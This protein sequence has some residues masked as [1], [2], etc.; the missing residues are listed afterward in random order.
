MFGP[1]DHNYSNFHDDVTLNDTVLN[2]TMTESVV[3]L[4]DSAVIDPETTICCC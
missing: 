4:E 1:F 2:V 3:P